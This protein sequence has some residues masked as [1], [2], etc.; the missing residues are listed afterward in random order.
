MSDR[1]GSSVTEYALILA[2]IAGSLVFGLEAVQFFDG[3]EHLTA[4]LSG[5]AT[6]GSGDSHRPTTARVT[7]AIV[8]P[9]DAV[10]PMLGLRIIV[11][12]LLVT[13]V[14]LALVV[15]RKRR[16]AEADEA[17]SEEAQAAHKKHDQ[18]RFVAKRQEI[19]RTLSKDVRFLM[20]SH[21]DVQKVMSNRVLTVLPQTTFEQV[22]LLMKEN[23][24]RHLLVTSAQQELLGVISDRDVARANSG[25]AQSIM[26]ANPACV[27]LTTPIRNAISMMLERH[28]SCLPVVD[29]GRA[30]GILTTTD[31]TMMLQCALQL[32][33]Q[34]DLTVKTPPA[35]VAESVEIDDEA[36]V[37]AAI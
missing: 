14:M 1:T 16:K 10:D 29:E 20:E 3:T 21:V 6:S 25:T 32:L 12:G 7:A 27:T 4:H 37:G 22:A 17:A 28:I 19:L 18:A 15:S 24:V 9:E 2:L 34:L 30:V 33:D 26:T 31:L 36:L 23:H 5:Q 8:S 11:L 35:S 13:T